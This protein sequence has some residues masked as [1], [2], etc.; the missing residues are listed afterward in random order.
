MR[1]VVILG[2]TGSIG[3]Q[4][5]D[6]ITTRPELFEVTGLAAGGSSVDLL[7]EQA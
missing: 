2:S 6:V 1:Q 5:I 3:T 4:A 7:V